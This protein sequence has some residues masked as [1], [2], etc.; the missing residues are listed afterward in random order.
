MH[1]RA[2]AER[3]ATE[4]V[5]RQAGI[6]RLPKLTAAALELKAHVL[7]DGQ[8]LL[9]RYFRLVG[10]DP[11]GHERFAPVAG[12][13][14]HRD[15]EDLAV[16]NGFSVGESAA[17][18]LVAAK[19]APAS[20][21]ALAAAL[22]KAAKRSA[23][24]AAASATGK[25]LEAA[26]P[27]ARST[28][29]AFASNVDEALLASRFED[30]VAITAS[31]FGLA[32]FM[33]GLTPAQLAALVEEGVT[34]EEAATGQPDFYRPKANSRAT[35]KFTPAALGCRAEGERTL[36]AEELTTV[37]LGHAF[38]NVTWF[39]H[40]LI[41]ALRLGDAAVAAGE[42]LLD[43]DAR[44]NGDKKANAEPFD[45]MRAEL[46]RK[47]LLRSLGVEPQ[48]I[49]KAYRLGAS[50]L[51]VETR[52]ATYARREDA[53]NALVAERLDAATPAGRKHAI[54]VAVARV[55][56]ELRK[57]RTNLLMGLEAA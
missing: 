3:V 35:G 12:A 32:D 14:W 21:S 29:A 6:G 50:Q 8:R 31:R 13:D 34:R 39:G 1:V 55:A 43:I 53:I 38:G 56:F 46:F 28:L 20:L 24:E 22:S 44:I 37:D 33:E 41:R 57:D 47:T 36:S 49:T 7:I 9:Q 19:I 16:R 30:E 11:R 10:T 54:Q 23:L 27:I 5:F 17:A 18:Q 48:E 45:V 2:H 52:V 4:G 42:D 26:G 51:D 40:Q 25:G 15:I